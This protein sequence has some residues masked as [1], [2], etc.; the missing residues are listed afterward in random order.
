MVRYL[1]IIVEKIT[2]IFDKQKE[3][4]IIVSKTIGEVVFDGS[5]LD[6][7]INGGEFTG[8]EDITYLIEIDGTGAPD[9]FKWS[10]DGGSAWIQETVNI[11]GFEQL[12]DNGVAVTFGDTTG[13]TLTDKWSFIARVADP[14]AVHKIP[15]NLNMPSLAP[16]GSV[17]F[18]P[19][20]LRNVEAV[21]LTIGLGFAGGA[22]AGVSVKALT[23]AD[24]V[25]Y[26][27]ESDPYAGDGLEPDFVAGTTVQ[28]TSLIDVMAIK[29]MKIKVENLDAGQGTSGQDSFITKVER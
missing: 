10:K 6:D 17:T 16:S 29:F 5:G 15:V 23:S 21:A 22:G 7:M 13:H 1:D 8:D 28:K 19:F 4:T 9:T 11:D 18:G 26:D 3:G 25:S 20:D 27:T 2:A 14:I 12:L 24:G